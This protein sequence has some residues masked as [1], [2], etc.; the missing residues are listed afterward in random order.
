MNFAEKIE[1]INKEINR[2]NSELRYSNQ[3]VG[4]PIKIWYDE[5]KDLYKVLH[6]G[7]DGYRQITLMRETEN[8]KFKYSVHDFYK[9]PKGIIIFG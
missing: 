8:K 7:V 2:I 6:K 9:E 5:E 1:K 3:S 4:S